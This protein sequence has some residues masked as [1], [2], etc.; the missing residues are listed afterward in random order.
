MSATGV[1]SFAS[2]LMGQAIEGAFGDAWMVPVV[3][4]ACQRRVPPAIVWLFIRV[5]T[6]AVAT[7]TH[8]GS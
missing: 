4:V 2:D 3:D 7:P 8:H 5:A 1:P 6:A